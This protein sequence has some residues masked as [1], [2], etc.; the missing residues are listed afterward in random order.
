MP[1]CWYCKTKAG[2]RYCSPIDNILCPICCA[3][4]RIIN[5]DCN[6]DCRYLEGVDY[7]KAR[8]EDRD[9]SQL[10]AS[11]PHGQYDDIF[12]DMAVALMAGEIEIFIRDI[13]I[14]G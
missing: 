11:V 13:Y 10:I 14:K 9:F 8:D 5:I 4:N 3:K 1:K 7:Q 2:K 12:Q 6:Q